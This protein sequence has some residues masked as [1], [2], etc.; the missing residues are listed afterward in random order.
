MFPTVRTIAVGILFLNNIAFRKDQFNYPTMRFF[1]KHL[2]PSLVTAII[3]FGCGKN[4]TSQDNASE[5]TSEKPAVAVLQKVK[6]TIGD[7][8]HVGFSGKVEVVR[9]QVDGIKSHYENAHDTIMFATGTLKT[10]WHQIVVSGHTAQK[11]SFSDTLRIELLSD[12][13]PTEMS[14]VV[15]GSFPH[16]ESSFTEG[17][18]FYKGELY[19]GT[20]QNGVSKLLKIDLPTGKTLM[21]TSLDAKYFGEGITVVNDKIYQ[22][23]WQSGVCFRY[24]MD[25]TL[26]K[27]FTY[28]TQGWGMTHRDSTIIISDGSSKL[29]FYNTE[30]VKTG[31]IDVYD[32]SG[33]VRQLNE[34]EFVDGYVYANIFES[35]RI[36]KIDI[37]TGKVVAFMRMDALVP[38]AINVKKDV[39]NGIAK[40]PFE[41]ALYLTGKNWP[42]LF[43]IRVK[44]PMPRKSRLL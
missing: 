35:T 10:G 4:G 32:Q 21:E 17:L 43:K 3:L 36:V 8:V 37:T 40:Q 33:P 22:L 26:E 34:L 42:Q 18:E 31:E 14:Y 19:E 12:L 15:L 1:S 25:F 23:T 41:N 2:L 9:V 20:G 28:Y 7:S 27:T 16:Q 5:A 38:P 44:D 29:Y 11:M 30:M 6:Y 24:K 39:L 13:D